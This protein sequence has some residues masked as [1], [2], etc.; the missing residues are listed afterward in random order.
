[1]IAS[2]DWLDWREQR[3]RDRPFPRNLKRCVKFN[4]CVVLNRC[5]EVNRCVYGVFVG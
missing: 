1:M 5:N 3:S 4:R 2:F